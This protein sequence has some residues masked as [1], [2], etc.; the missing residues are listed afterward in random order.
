[1]VKD[2]YVLRVPM[3]KKE[4]SDFNKAFKSSGFKTMAEFVRFV[5]REYF[6]K[7]KGEK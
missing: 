5:L 3:G 2:N 6:I 4:Q 1:M 7:A